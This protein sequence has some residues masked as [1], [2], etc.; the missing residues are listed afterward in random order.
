[1]LGLFFTTAYAQ[2]PGAGD[3]FKGLVTNLLIPYLNQLFPIILGLILLAFVWGLVRFLAAGGDEKAL[4]SGKHIMF[5]GIIIFVVVVSFWGI[6]LF[7]QQALNLNSGGG[8][9]VP[10][11][12]TSSR[13]FDPTA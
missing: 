6:V 11:L 5:W 1:M 2:S 3:G 10:S 8:V 12:P 7:M 4:E 13:M 9:V